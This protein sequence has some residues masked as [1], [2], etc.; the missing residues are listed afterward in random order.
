MQIS[1]V[2]RKLSSQTSGYA[3]SVRA[4]NYYLLTSGFEARD[5]VIMLKQFFA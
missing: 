3:V 1:Q 5:E 2:Y 4:A